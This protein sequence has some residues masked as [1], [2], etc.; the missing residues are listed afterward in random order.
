MTHRFPRLLAAGGVAL[1]LLALAACTPAEA[2]TSTLRVIRG[3]SFDGW[4]PDSAAAYATY[5]TL[6]NVL[7]PLLRSNPDGTTVDPG[8]ATAWE[9]DAAAH[10]WT[11]TLRD[12]AAFSDGSPLTSK[13]VA[14]SL[15]IWQDG[16]NFGSLYA[17]IEGVTT[18][19]EHTVVFQMTGPETTLPILMTWTS[20]AI[21]PA[22]FGGRTAEEFFQKPIGAGAFSVKSW[23]T[24]GEIVLAA[25]EH[26]YEPVGVERVVIK[27][28]TDA[29]QGAA[30][31]ESGQADIS[32]YL[33]A[34]DA[35]I[36]G[37]ALVP[38]PPSQI[39]HLS[40]NI[41]RTPLDDPALR[42]AIAAAIDY[43]NL[44][45]GAFKGYGVEA[46]GILPSTIGNWAAPAEVPIAFDLDAARAALDEV[47]DVPDTLEVVYDASNQ[48]DNV[49]AQ[50]LKED[51]AAIGIDLTLS[52]L[53]T[54]TFLDRAYGGDADLV[55]WSY[56]AISPDV[57]DPFG[58]IL[59]TGWLY[60]GF[61]TTELGEQFTAYTASETDAEKQAIAGHM[62]DAAN[63]DVP[64]VALAEFQVL[65]ALSDRTEGFAATPWGMYRWA[66]ITLDG[67]TEGGSAG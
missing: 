57:V 59:G 2:D 23:S 6:D 44:I 35:G 1:A 61:D 28:V 53:E 40:F 33:A 9:Y 31:I 20:A 58:W 32:E 14:F 27:T 52:P 15:D 60:S 29:N 56:G 38:L 37:D 17:G 67:Q 16:P 65:Y 7:E 45:E 55:L 36:Y 12:D 46:Q 63:R 54:G 39:E 25:N 19:D 3:E 50:I 42:R 48:T 10:T 5:Q 66:S 8:I 41:A 11:F 26:Y 34:A 62:Q 22:D 21:Y 47:A 13:D 64:A 49:V 30:L 4:N 43:P 51:L 18:P 24:G